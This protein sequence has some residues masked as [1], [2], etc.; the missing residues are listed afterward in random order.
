MQSKPTYLKTED[1][2]TLGQVGQEATAEVKVLPR[3]LHP[4]KKRDGNGKWS[5]GQKKD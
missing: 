3:P 4:A 2:A 1:G 5:E